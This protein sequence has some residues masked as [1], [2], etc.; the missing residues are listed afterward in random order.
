MAGRSISSPPTAQFLPGYG[1][2]GLFG[3]PER[4]EPGAFIAY[5]AAD[6]DA[7]GLLDMLGYRLWSGGGAYI[8]MLNHADAAQR[9]SSA[10]TDSSCA[11]RVRCAIRHALAGR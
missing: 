4:F 1:A 7:D 8:V 5:L 11:I 2:P 3:E 9:Q 6:F 10:G